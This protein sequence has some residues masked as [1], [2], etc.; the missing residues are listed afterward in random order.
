MLIFEQ[1]DRFPPIS[2][3]RLYFENII[4]ELRLTRCELLRQKK[5]LAFNKTIWRY[6]CRYKFFS[7]Y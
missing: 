5:M 3:F 4:F 1:N 6:Y 7:G 2:S